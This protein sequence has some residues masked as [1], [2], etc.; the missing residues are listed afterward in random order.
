VTVQDDHAPFAPDQFTYLQV[1]DRIAARIRAGES[2]ESGKLP[3]QPA[4]CGH[5]GV[6]AGVVRHAWQELMRRGLVVTVPGKGTFI[7]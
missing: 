3:S 6:G 5:Y 4:T 1:A 2:G 7:T